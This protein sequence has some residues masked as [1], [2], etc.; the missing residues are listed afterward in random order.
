MFFAKPFSGSFVEASRL[1]V[2]FARKSNIAQPRT[3][4]FFHGVLDV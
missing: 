2:Y 3:R 4:L 1:R